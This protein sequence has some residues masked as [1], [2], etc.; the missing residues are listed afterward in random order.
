MDACDVDTFIKS[1]NAW[2]YFWPVLVTLGLM[3]PEGWMQILGRYNQIS[4]LV[5]A[6]GFRT[7]LEASCGVNAFRQNWTCRTK[8]QLDAC[9]VSLGLGCWP[10][11]TCQHGQRARGAWRWADFSALSKPCVETPFPGFLAD[12]EAKLRN[13]MLNE[14]SFLCWWVSRCSKLFPCSVNDQK[15]P[16]GTQRCVVVWLTE[17]L[18]SR[19]C[20][21]S[22]FCDRQQSPVTPLLA[23]PTHLM[24]AS[25]SIVS[26]NKNNFALKWSL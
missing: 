11:L 24:N 19:K 16:N 6:E 13:I 2:V 26:N 18:Q 15:V 23:Y 1:W 14:I 21:L 5:E 9:L 4:P 25:A 22:S 17:S 3:G 8:F 10:P 20:P 12:M 7:L